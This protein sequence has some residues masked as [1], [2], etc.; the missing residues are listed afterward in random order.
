ME[1]TQSER[2]YLHRE[3]AEARMPKLLTLEEFR[4]LGCP[5]HISV[6]AIQS[7]L[8]RRAEKLGPKFTDIRQNLNAGETDALVDKV[9]AASLF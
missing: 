8:E 5:D 2:R 3:H 4:A 1:F 6:P 7:Q 9:N